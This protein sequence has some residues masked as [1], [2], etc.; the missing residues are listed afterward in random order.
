MKSRSCAA[1]GGR[2]WRRKAMVEAAVGAICKQWHDRA[3]MIMIHRIVSCAI[4]MVEGGCLLKGVM[5]P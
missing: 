2:K 1:P 4:P 3:D 5:L